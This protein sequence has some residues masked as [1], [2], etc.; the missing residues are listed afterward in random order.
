MSHY[1]RL[2]ILAACLCPPLVGSAQS[3]EGRDQVRIRTSD[4]RIIHLDIEEYLK[5][6]LPS[7]MSVKWPLEAL[8]AQAIAA[9]S[10]AMSVMH[11]R[12]YE[13]YDV[14]DTIRHQVF[15]MKNFNQA[16]LPD[17]RKI[18]EAIQA[19][20]GLYLV[21]ANGEIYRTF[22]H[23]DCGGSTEE[24]QV[25]WGNTHRNGTVKDER[26]RL[27]PRSLW[28][29]E[30]PRDSLDRKLRALFKLADEYK[31]SALRADSYTTSGRINE[32][33]I[34][35][36]SIKKNGNPRAASTQEV[37]TIKA[38]DFRQLFGFNQVKSTHFEMRLSE[39]TLE[40]KGR[41][42][43]HGAGMCQKS[44][45]FMALDGAKFTDILQRYYPHARLKQP[46]ILAVSK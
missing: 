5:G 15:N 10:Y 9:R 29:Y 39:R 25:V 23:S 37:R 6:V 26:C 44:A 24:P 1:R 33:A 21:D 3:L 34:E 30:I 8:K 42:H 19:T 41:G 20:R 12:A 43:G 32:L 31:I 35:F 14:S 16:N 46:A 2:A 13:P 11:E 18:L 38:Q 22:F 36:S 27:N 40:L 4:A 28:R 7:E 45:R 17:K